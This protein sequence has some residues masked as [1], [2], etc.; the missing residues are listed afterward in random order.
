M[1]P[2]DGRDGPLD[3]IEFLARSPNRVRVLD[4]LTDGPVGRYDLE[5]ATGVARATLGRILEDFTARNWV[6]EADRAYETTPL[7]DYVSRSIEA[8]LE[9]FEPVP[10]LA[11][12]AEWF[13]ADGFGFD[14]G[15][16]AG[17]TVIRSTKHDAL[18]P[19]THIARRIRDADRVRL[20]TYAVLPGVMEAC[21]RGAVE[22]GLELEGVLEARAVD[23]VGS[24]P[25]LVAQA[26]E[27]FETGRAEVYVYRGD[28][29]CTFFVVDDVVLL[30]LSGGEGAPLAVLETDAEAVL[31]WAEATLEAL[32]SEGER[33]DP[34]LFTG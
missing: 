25:Q 33:L 30:C 16:L 14:L 11:E 1:D 8:A 2:A 26:R 27:L 31:G 4:A 32:R 22:R 10:T 6:V 21:W 7:G 29:P 24:D 23:G 5:D 28:V 3:V 19:T 13:P 34:T 18:A 20:V 17:A 12:V 15:H 9:R